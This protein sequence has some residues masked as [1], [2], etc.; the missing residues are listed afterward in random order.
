MKGS[1]Q[2]HQQLLIRTQLAI[3][4]AIPEA[5]LF[6]RHV[7][8]FYTKNKVPISIGMKG[9]AD[10]VVYFSVTV[11][12]FT[13][14]LFCEIEFKTGNSTQ[15]KEQKLWGKFISS[16]GGL[17]IVARNEEDTVNQLLT[18]RDSIVKKMGQATNLTH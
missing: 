3:Q 1:Y 18:F 16:L 15:S 5:R 17:Y 10:A 7:G 14:P 8:L 6:P 2:A 13:L 4:K 9:Q 12:N 11:G